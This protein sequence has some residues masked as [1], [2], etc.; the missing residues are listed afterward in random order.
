MT[1]KANSSGTSPLEVLSSQ[2]GPRSQGTA[3]LGLSTQDPAHVEKPC[4]S[5]HKEARGWRSQQKE[6]RER[7]ADPEAMLH[8]GSRVASPVPS[9][10]QRIHNLVGKASPSPPK[11]CMEK[12]IRQGFV[13]STRLECSGLII[14]HCSLNLLGSSHP[15]ISASTA[16]GTT[17]ACHHTWIIF[18]KICFVETGF[19]YVALADL[20]LLASRDSPASA[21]QSTEITGCSFR[22]DFPP[23]SFQA[24]THLAV[25]SRRSSL[26][27]ESLGAHPSSLSRQG[28]LSLGQVPKSFPLLPGC[29]AGSRS[30]LTVTFTFRVQAILLPQLLKITGTRLH[31]Q[32]FFVCL[33]ETR[34]HHVDQDGLD[35]LTS[36]S[37]HFGLPKCWDYRCEPPCPAECLSLYNPRGLMNKCPPRL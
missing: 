31:T 5:R 16:A 2:Q 19:H 11:K 10:K 26:S 12:T 6:R 14:A 35:L 4:S 28:C 18:L 15:P 21:S 32:L 34:F 37:A 25:S 29:S 13:L 20:K 8:Q 27:L 7:G 9:Q 30:H 3:C 1:T 33:V 17:G 22:L 36:R 24:W 23:S